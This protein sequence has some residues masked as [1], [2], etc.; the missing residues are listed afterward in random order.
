MK[1]N[2]M[3]CPNCGSKN[4]YA[5]SCVQ[6]DLWDDEV[7]GTAE[8]RPERGHLLSESGD[9]AIFEYK[10]EN[11]EKHFFSLVFFRAEV[12]R[13]VTGKTIGEIEALKY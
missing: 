1:L 4:T 5:H 9:N 13:T 2:G 11:C 8:M 10:C 6:T 7:Y 12:K 3:E